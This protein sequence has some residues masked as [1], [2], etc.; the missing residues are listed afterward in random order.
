M[1]W[2]IE[3]SGGNENSGVMTALA[4]ISSASPKA[5]RVAI[6]ALARSVVM[7]GEGNQRKCENMKKS[8]WR[9]GVK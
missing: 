6:I 3:S 4:E 7:S 9:D 5:A 2:R 1:A 8:R